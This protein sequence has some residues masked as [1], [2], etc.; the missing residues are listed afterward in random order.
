[1]LFYLFKNYQKN[2]KEK[3]VYTMKKKEKLRVKQKLD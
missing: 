3:K 2:I 1:M